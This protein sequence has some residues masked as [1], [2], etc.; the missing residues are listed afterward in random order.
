MPQCFEKIQSL[1]V[2]IYL[3]TSTETQMAQIMVQRGR[4][5]HSSWTKSVRSSTGRPFYGEGNSRKFYW[6][7]VGKK[8]QIG[9][10]HLQTEKKYYSCLCMWTTQNWLERNKTLT[11]CGKHL[12]KKSIWASQ[13]PSLT[14]FIWVALNESAKWATILWTITETCMNLGSLL[15]QQKSC[16]VQGN[17]TQTFPHGSLASGNRDGERSNRDV[18][19]LWNVDY[20]PTNTHS[21]Q[22]ESQLYIC[23][24]TKAVQKSYDETRIKNPLDQ[25]PNQICW[26]QKPTRRHVDQRYFYTW[27]MGPSSLIVGH[28][29]FLDV[30]MQPFSF[31]RKAECYV[32][33]QE[34]TAK[35]G[36]AVAKRRPMSL[37]GTS[38]AQS[39]LL[40]KIRVLW[41]ARRIKSWIRVLFLELVR[42]S[43]PD[44]TTHSQEWQQDDNPFWGTRK[45]VR[46]GQCASSASTRKLERG[47]GS[48]IE[49]TRLEFHPQYANLRSSIPRES[50]QE[51]AA[52]VE[53]R[54]RGT[55]TRL[56]DQC[57]DLGILRVNNEESRCSSWT[58]L[59]RT[60]G[61]TQEHKPRRAQE[62]VR[63]RSEIDIGTW[64]RDSE[65]ITDW[66]DSSII[67]RD[68][69]LRVIKWSRGRKQEHAS[70]QI[71]SCAWRKG[72][73]I[74][75]RIEDGKIKK[76]I[77][78]IRFLQRG[79]FI[80]CVWGHR[81]SD[82][83]DH[84]GQKSN[85]ET[86]VKNPQRC[87]S[88]VIRQNQFG[89]QDPNQLCWHQKLT[90]RRVKPKEAADV[91]VGTIFFVCWIPW[92]PRCFLA[93]VLF[94]QKAECHVQGSSGK[95]FWRR[96][97]SGETETNEFGVKERPECEDNPSARF[98]CF[99]QLGNPELDQSCVSSSSR[100]L[101][102][103]INLNPTIYSQERQ[104][105]DT[106]SSSTRKR[107]RRDE[108]SSEVMTSKSEGQRWNS[109]VCRSPTISTSK[110]S[111]R[112]CGKGEPHRRGTNDWYWSFEDQRIDVGIIY[113]DNDER[114]HS[115][116]TKLHW[117]FWSI[118]EHTL[119]G[120]SEF[121]QDHAEFDVESSSRNAECMIGQLHHGR[122]P[123]LRMIKWSRGRKQK[124]ASTQIPSYVWRRCKSIQKRTKDGM[125]NSSFDSPFLKAN[126]LE[127]ME[128]RLSSSG[129]FPRTH[130]IGDL[131][132]DPKRSA[133]SKHWTWTFWRTDH[134][135][136]NVQWHR[137]DNERKFRKVYLEFRRSH[138]LREEIVA[139]TLVIPRP[140]WWKEMVRNSQ[141][142]TWR[143]MGFHSRRDGGTIQRNQS[144]SSQGVD[145]GQTQ[146]W[147]VIGENSGADVEW[148]TDKFNLGTY[149][150]EN[151][152]A[153]LERTNSTSAGSWVMTFL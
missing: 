112:T 78:T 11:Q 132:E 73:I 57:L 2:Q 71:P 51:L 116:W 101:T 76:K 147:P 49:R 124:Y 127:L 96:F 144:S 83:N 122:D 99:E 74:Q 45:L 79:S 94:K 128:N 53:S 149:L 16:L 152:G 40:R 61:S 5:S 145:D 143:K 31:D 118:Q 38:W 97:G 66:L 111:S 28:H 13:D 14:T 60:F 33:E 10:A 56:E 119:R 140:R 72:Q 20:V 137:L 69:H 37:H 47:D 77:S 27:W 80:V 15:E 25:D 32:Q 93:A 109:T 106:L 142:H 43:D 48:K 139:R 153:D 21:S 4:P 17:L 22:G 62:F 107:V 126:E 98:E 114:R 39:K 30:F 9:N 141:L 125:L 117:E 146:S 6:N 41:T 91:M 50:L 104:Q 133:R 29:E 134:L 70:T 108:P 105:D 87:S 130:F 44:P 46:S 3:D 121:I 82:Q 102:R 8:F 148:M 113:V 42:D 52:K 92:I 36:S 12:W 100:K 67:G 84:E 18:D 26:H 34:S 24:D 85:N 58:K 75:K 89:P 86:R 129:I 81:S 138:E 23:E 7:T 151:S 95:H 19:Q 68:L 59:Q 55:S 90:R 88:L 35:E 63:H 123:H 65:C 150:M 1:N 103:N 120:T 64:S 131:P 115:S 110:K 135:H 136:V 54:R